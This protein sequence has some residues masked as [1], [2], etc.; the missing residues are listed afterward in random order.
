MNQAELCTDDWPMPQSGHIV[1][2]YFRCCCII[3]ILICPLIVVVVEGRGSFSQTS[4]VWFHNLPESSTSL[5]FLT[6]SQEKVVCH[7]VIYIDF[8]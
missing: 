4:Q 3:L 6:Q 7:C 2:F 8:R 5:A 1:L